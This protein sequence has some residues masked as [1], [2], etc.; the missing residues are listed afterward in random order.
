MSNVLNQ[1]LGI[2]NT[3]YS[4]LIA[5]A[6]KILTGI[7][8]LI[9]GWLL[10]SFVAF[11]VRK[12]L[13]TLKVDGLNDNLQQIDLFK[14]LDFQLS[15]FISKILF[16]VI[17]LLFG[18]VSFELMG[19]NSVSEGI[20]SLIG[21]LP[22]LLSAMV[23]FILG[24]LIANLI[25]EVVKG[26]CQALNLAGASVI[27]AFVFYFILIMVAITALNQAGMDTEIITQNVTIAMGAII[28][29]FAI[30]YGFASKDIMANILASF[31]SRDKFQIGQRIKVENVEGVIVKVDG[32]S[33]I[34]QQ[35]NERKVILP[36]HKL[37]VANVELIG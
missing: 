22:K 4:D 8:L 28:F 37:L 18:M 34:I 32:M 3:M 9:L 29:A 24:A 1:L 10:A 5:S 14:H 27:S 15:R 35:D 33:V 23:F 11:I 21:Y 17:M 36:L 26:A 30:G 6:P 2:L 31:Y 19:L 12:I 7:V 25:R 13:V 16:W 20:K